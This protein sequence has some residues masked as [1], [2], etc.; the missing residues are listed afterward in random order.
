MVIEGMLF[1][2]GARIFCTGQIMPL[3]SCGADSALSQ[4]PGHMAQQ[5]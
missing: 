2:A 4:N 5:Q 1:L 3:H